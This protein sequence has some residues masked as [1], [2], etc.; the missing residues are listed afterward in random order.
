M[1][2]IS[3]P[4]CID[5]QDGAKTH[6]MKQRGAREAEELALAIE[7]LRL[8]SDER[9]RTRPGGPEYAAAQELEEHLNEIVLEMV[10]RHNGAL[11]RGD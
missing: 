5:V 1:R 7:Q 9:D 4:A 6:D 11:L 10:R 2:G 3:L 8:A